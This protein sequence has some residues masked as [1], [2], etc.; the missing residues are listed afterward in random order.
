M[1]IWRV[2]GTRSAARGRPRRRTA[3]SLDTDS[4]PVG[5]CPA[6]DA[7]VSD[8]AEVVSSRSD[9]EDGRLGDAPS[10]PRGFEHGAATDEPVE[11]SCPTGSRRGQPPPLR[12]TP[13]AP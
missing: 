7:F 6:I 13:P 4:E 5:G 8:R 10:P 12:P 2:R 9:Q 3:G 1:I 11:E